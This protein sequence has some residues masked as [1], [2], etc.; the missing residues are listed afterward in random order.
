MP[1]GWSSDGDEIALGGVR[2]KAIHT[3]GHTPEH[4]AWALFDDT[5]SKDTPWL[6]FTGDFLFVGDVGRPDLLGEEAR[7]KLAHQLYESVFGVLPALPDFTEIFPAH[8]AGSL[9]GKAIGSRGASTR[10]LRAAVQRGAPAS[11][12]SRE[13]TDD[14]AEGHAARPALLPPDE[15]GQRRGAEGPRPRACR[16]RSGSRR[17]RSTSGSASTAWSWT[18]GPRR[19]SP[20]PTSPARSTSRWA[21]TCRPG[22]AGCCRT[23]ARS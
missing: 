1:T 11:R 14:A 6:I 16:A 7:R 4:V 18:C 12:P 3:P 5:R 2:L 9:C 23:T 8:G 22:R 13:W 19:R 21:T 15:E 20:P 17:R 10:R